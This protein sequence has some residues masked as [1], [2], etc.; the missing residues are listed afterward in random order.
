MDAAQTYASLVNSVNAQRER[1]HGK[2]AEGDSWGGLTARRFRFDPRRELDAD[3]QIIASYVEQPDI[4]IDVGGGAGRFCLPLA[5]RC[6][7]VINV[8]P[9][10]GMGAEFQASAAE[11]GITNFRFIEC[12]W[13]EADG[14]QGEVTL[15]ANVTYFVSD[16]LSFVHNLETA[17]RRRVIINV[18]SVPNPNQNAELFRL[19][20]GEKQEML[21]GHQ[22]LLPVLWEM[23]ILPDMR[24]LPDVPIV[25]GS[26]LDTQLPQTMEE[27]LQL[28]TQGQWL[29]SKEQD[30]ARE[31]ITDRFDEFFEE[32]DGGFLPRWL[33]DARQLLITWETGHSHRE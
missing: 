29:G 26:P 27:A 31:L 13:L 5:L 28:A 10:P 14:I 3:L 33:P 17:S 7:E 11:A 15:A 1:V 24:V 25:P 32:G 16:I 4:L 2:T 12:D 30:R 18:N 6:R 19:V 22:E 23:G 9:S 8:D 21:P 20:Y